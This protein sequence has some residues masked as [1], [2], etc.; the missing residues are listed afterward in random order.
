MT[1]PGGNRGGHQ[2]QKAIAETNGGSNSAATL[3]SG[4]DAMAMPRTC[5]EA[6]APERAALQALRRA[7]PEDRPMW[8]KLY[9]AFRAARVVKMSNAIMGD[10]S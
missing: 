7:L 6:K 4:Q 10:D 8:L 5:R 1:A 9:C 2:Q 3:C